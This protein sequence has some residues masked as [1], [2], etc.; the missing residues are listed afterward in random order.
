M[1][2]TSVS[3]LIES[4]RLLDVVLSHTP[5]LAAFLDTRFTFVWVNP[6]FAAD[7]RRPPD[8]F[9]GKNLFDLYPSDRNKA[10]FQRV[11]DGGEPFQF[12]S[13]PIQ[14]SEQ[15]ERGMTYWDGSLVP[16]R[17]D[18]GRI[19]GLVLTLSEVTGRMRAEQAL[20]RSENRYHELVEL[21]S[22]GILLGSHE[23]VII[24]A[25]RRMRELTGLGSEALIGMHIRNAPFT[26]ESVERSPFRFDLLKAGQPVVS[27]RTLVRPDGAE[28]EVEMRS[29]MMP[30]GTYQ[31]IFRD[32]SD[33]KRAAAELLEAEWKFRALFEQ[34]PIGVAYHEMLYD[35]S[36]AAVDY[37]FIDANASYCE[38]TGVDPRGKTVRQAFPGIEKDTFDW[39]GTFDRVLRTGQ[40]I[41]FEQYLSLN[42]RWYDCVAYRYK[43]RHFV[44]A[45]LEITERKRTQEKL[46]RT[47]EELS[48]SNTDLEQ[49]AYIASHDMKEPLRMVTG[50]MSLL[51][52]RYGGTLD[53]AAGEYI[54]LA[55]E[56][57]MRMQQ[58]VDDLLAYARIGREGQ[59]QAV[60]AG[61]ALD[62]A[63]KNL[64]ASISEAGAV[65]T[66][67]PLPSLRASDTE[68]VQLFQNLIA[69]AIK[70]R[71]PG[72]APRI[73]VSALREADSWLFRVRD[74]GIGIAPEYR[75]KVFLIF[76]RLHAP[77]AFPGTGIGLALCKKIVTR[78][79]GKIWVEGDEPEGCTF[80][81]T[82]PA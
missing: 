68:V 45:F 70:F 37:R 6:A 53:G 60:D 51:R 35:A 79:G 71:R 81:F 32:I 2:F 20:E 50:F 43:P 76:Q 3:E 33:R 8:F 29:K 18:G 21:A 41:R 17:N 10:I 9:P 82:F 44:V 52:E 78:H 19:D 34:G 49:F 15:P 62:G 54:G 28:V 16:V 4:N 39:I 73:H 11:V 23:G 46:K 61:A 59:S 42:D 36:G 56:G 25:N 26:P 7:S 77:D 67:E 66:H 55:L 72:V 64:Q 31:S 14:F 69:N 40:S 74:N 22:D 63:L 57:G 1:E 38:L 58:L 12:K 80:C 65:I 47:A 48:R 75:E 24:E 5:V 27:E 30:D 13:E